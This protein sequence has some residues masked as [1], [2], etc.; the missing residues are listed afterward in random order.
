VPRRSWSNLS[1]H[2]SCSQPLAKSFQQLR[3]SRGVVDQASAACG[4]RVSNRAAANGG[5]S[6]EDPRECP[7][8]NGHNT[9]SPAEPHWPRGQEVLEKLAQTILFMGFT[10][11]RP[12]SQC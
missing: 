6:G 10:A 9:W 1:T 5:N 2:R 4:N 3:R 7:E 8:R 12:R 11:H